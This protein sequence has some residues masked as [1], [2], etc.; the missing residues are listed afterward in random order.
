M[1]VFEDLEADPRRGAA[2][3]VGVLTVVSG[4]FLLAFPKTALGL[5]GAGK[6]DPAPYLFGIIGMFMLLFGGLLIDT[7][8]RL[9]PSPV[10]LFWCM[11][12]K[13][14]ATIAMVVGYVTDVYGWFAL[15]VAIVDGASALIIRALWRREA[16]RQGP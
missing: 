10:A 7:A 1:N 6:A 13:I 11:L 9:E 5:I 8:R 14:G 12:Q 4:L 2:V 3:A 15:F 16:M